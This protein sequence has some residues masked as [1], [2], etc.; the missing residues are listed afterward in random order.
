MGDSPD[1]R[2]GNAQIAAGEID[3]VELLSS[4]SSA[5][6]RSQ[7]FTD[8]TFNVDGSKIFAHR[9]VLAARS[10]YFRA[11]LYGGM[12]ETNPETE[13]EIKDTTASAFD[14]LLKYIY[15]GKIFLGDYKEETILELLSLAHKYGFLALE[16]ALQG[17]LKSILS[18]RNICVIFDAAVLYQMNDL[19]ATCLS[20]LDRNA[21]EVLSTDG[22][23][24]LTKSALTE[25][26]KRDSF[27]APE[28]QIFR[29]VQEWVES[30][31]EMSEG[32]FKDILDTVRLPLISLHDLFNTVRP[33][34]LYSA[35]A[36]LD[37]IQIKTESRVHEMNFRGHLVP[38][39]NIA[40]SQ[41]GAEVIEGEMRE[42]LLDG[43]TTNFDLDRGFTR[44]LILE[45]DKGICI[46]LGRPS[47][48]N[49]IKMLLWNKDPRSYSY[50][51]EVSVDNE[52]W[53]RV[54]DYSKYFCRSWQRLYFK[55]RV[56]RYIR[57]L[58]VHNTVNKV[59]HLVHFECSYSNTTYQLGE[60]GVI[61]PF[62]NVALPSLGASVIEGVSR[63]RNALL[64][65]EVGNYDWNIGYTCHQLGSGAIV[66]QLPQPY[67][68]STMRLLLWDLDER[69]YSYF[70]E[71]SCDQQS[72]VRVVDKT[73]EVCRSWQYLSFEPRPVVFVRIVGV[74]NTA[75][76]VFHCV[77]FEC[78]ANH[79]EPMNCSSEM[80]DSSEQS[81]ASDSTI[82][83]IM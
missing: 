52:D 79:K 50:Y 68:V 58:G 78:P 83:S 76:E 33:S 4:Q 41:H 64:N 48:I 71:V 20:F 73:K 54:I 17:Y 70:I 23:S 47:I 15:S 19:C 22:F 3:H 12:R 74:E 18:I 28:N 24:C 34:E 16:S 27:C 25:V 42:S 8:V 43:D 66:V 75:N 69:K 14:A 21:V 80:T 1:L 77:H 38:D 57:V 55:P 56:V 26:V 31:E 40:T 49:N 62:E 6:F 13:I 35:D 67:I 37:A 81:A 30:A 46:A 45:G 61:V 10:E 72:W 36:I 9:V 5:L 11:L 59:F 39:E 44:H 2:L 63:S 32:D 65:G 29:A 82:S 51:I 53:I 7:E 60:D